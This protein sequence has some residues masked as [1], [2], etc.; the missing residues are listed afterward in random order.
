MRE[1]ISSLRIEGLEVEVRRRAVR[2]I[3]IVITP[4]SGEVVVTAPLGSSDAA[5]LALLG[6]R[7]PW[8]RKHRE[9]MAAV[10][11][12]PRL[13]YAEGESIRLFGA[14]LALGLVEGPSRKGARL[15]ADGDRLELRLPPGSSR[16]ERAA[17]VEAFYRS[18]L[19]KAIPPLAAK[20]ESL[21][22]VRVEAWGVKR[23][24]TRWGTCNPRARRVWLNLEL[25]RR[26]PECL[27]YVLVHEMAHLI[28]R[29]HDARFKAV[30][31]RALPGWR[32]TKKLLAS[33][34]MAED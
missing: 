13:D 17:L 27:E 22:G 12:A 2:T 25:A 28:E 29:S 31:D 10:A 7:L 32:L 9:R 26:P 30:L 23:M 8:I 14:D 15:A 20:W 16:E 1:T 5:L 18:E 21:L 11:P 33:E 3:R 19:K 24:K 34:A 6:K 4:P